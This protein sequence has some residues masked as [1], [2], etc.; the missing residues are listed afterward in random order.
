MMLAVSDTSDVV[1]TAG[2]AKESAYQLVKAGKEIKRDYEFCLFNHTTS[3]A[4]GY[5]GTT[6][7]APTMQSMADWVFKVSTSTGYS[8]TY[9]VGGLGQLSAV[10]TGAAL[11]E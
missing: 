5:A 7:A 2:R 11:T 3:G 8:G 1:N 6:S 4:S 10:L 9:V